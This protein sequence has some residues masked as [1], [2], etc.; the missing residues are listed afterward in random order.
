ME[1][2]LGTLNSVTPLGLVGLS[3]LIIYQIF[4][5]N[6]DVSLIKTNHLHHLQEDSQVLVEKL[7]T[8]N[9]TMERIE[10]NLSDHGD[11]EIELMLE[12]RAKI[13]NLTK[14]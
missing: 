12:V 14:K 9:N 13:D 10:R 5:N 8:L 11:R 6:K 1:N 2:L 3:L 7:E 4:K